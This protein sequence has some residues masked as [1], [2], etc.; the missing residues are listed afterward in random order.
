M[1]AYRF[2]ALEPDDLDFLSRWENDPAQWDYSDL[3]APLS[4]LQLGNYIATYDPDPF[5]AGQLRMIVEDTDKQ[6]PV[7]IVDLYKVNAVHARAMVGIF[8]DPA[9]RRCGVATASLRRLA[10]YSRQRL[11]LQQLTVIISADNNASIA[12]FRRCG[13]IHTG[14]LRKWRRLTSGFVDVEIY[15]L[16]F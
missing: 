8:I 14:T 9:Y 16:L 5:R 1:A 4:R 11:G 10:S 2:R 15:Q 3:V 6:Q 13:Y 7:G 12:L